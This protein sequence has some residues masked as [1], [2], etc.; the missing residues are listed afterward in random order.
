MSDFLKTSQVL[1]LGRS[2]GDEDAEAN[3][4][5]L[6][7]VKKNEKKNNVKNGMICLIRPGMNFRL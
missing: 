5:S 1:A 4:S 2:S 3:H 7:K 6:N